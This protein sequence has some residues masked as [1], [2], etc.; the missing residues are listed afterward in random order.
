MKNI[1]AEPPAATLAEVDGG[2]ILTM[3]RELAYPP[4]RVWRILTEPERLA[5]WSPIVP[6]RA[7]TSVG[8]AQSREAPDAPV[9]DVEV[10]VSDAPHTLVHRWGTHLLR[11]TLAPTETGT[12]LTLA[13]TLDEYADGS[14]NGAGWHICF[15]TLAAYLGDATVD[16]VV[17]GDATDYGWAGLRDR[18]DQILAG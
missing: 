12:R 18:Y 1:E 6:D 3:T 4:E 8:P 10:L 13:D 14:R 15:A 2:W 17:G 7:L 5:R 11:W 9:V 16:R